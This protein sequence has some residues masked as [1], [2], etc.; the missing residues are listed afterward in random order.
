MRRKAMAVAYCPSEI[1]TS[2]N[3]VS[4]IRG[5]HW[6]FLLVALAWLLGPIAP[7][8]RG[9]NTSDSIGVPPFSELAPIENGYI[10]LSNGDMHLEIPLGS[11]PQRVGRRFKAELMYDSRIWIGDSYIGWTPT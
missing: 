1:V 10:N 5:R 4:G 9:Q 2:P 8:V 3:H 11:F 7:T 6:T